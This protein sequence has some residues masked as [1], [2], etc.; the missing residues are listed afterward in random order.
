ME[1]LSK[2]TQNKK[3][4]ALIIIPGSIDFRGIQ[5]FFLNVLKY[6][7]YSNL[8]I[9]VYFGGNCN[10]AEI[11]ANLKSYGVGLYIGNS[12][13]S[14]RKNESKYNEDIQTLLR[15]NDYTC[16]YVNS[17]MP[18]FNYLALTDAKKFGVPKRISHSHSAHVPS[19]KVIVRIFQSLLRLESNS[20]ATDFLACSE[21]AGIWMFGKR[22]MREEGKILYNG[23]DAKRYAY[24]AMVRDEYRRI[25]GVQEK[26]VV[27]HVGAFNSAKNQRFLIEILGHLRD[28][29]KDVVFVLIGNGPNKDEIC[30]LADQL[31]VTER[32][33]FV[34]E[35][36][37]VE[38]YMQMADLFV[39]PSIFEGLGIVNIEAQAS[40]LKCLV[41]DVVPRMIDVTGLVT[42]KSLS[43]GPEEWAQVM[44]EMLNPYERK[45]T[46]SMIEDSGFDAKN[47]AEILQRIITR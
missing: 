45:N 19:K 28:T 36:S 27:L 31:D 7:N 21:Q 37:H 11:A 16:V 20:I 34:P 5:V 6:F 23:I 15:E 24:N 2:A 46:V 1:I 4:R 43:D 3:N 9:D 39:L 17:G 26:S 10:N 41:S 38:N 47:T 12:D 40:G 18:W 35:T 33:I 29:S 22:K 14:T 25:Y 13:L 30:Y 44:S 8:S 42:F 32:I